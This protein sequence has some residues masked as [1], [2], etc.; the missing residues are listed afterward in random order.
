M[1]RSGPKWREERT[2]IGKQVTPANVYGYVPGFNKATDRLVRNI[3]ELR[4]SD[5]YVKDIE[6]LVTYWSLEGIYTE[7]NNYSSLYC[8]VFSRS[9]F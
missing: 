2:R 7:C 6:E 9:I 3:R 4:E 8:L 5:G 1:N